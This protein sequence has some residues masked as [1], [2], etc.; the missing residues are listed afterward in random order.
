MHAHASLLNE[1]T[2]GMELIENESLQMPLKELFTGVLTR[3]KSSISNLSA[4]AA[5]QR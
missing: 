3:W 1:A 2:D 5:V 4:P